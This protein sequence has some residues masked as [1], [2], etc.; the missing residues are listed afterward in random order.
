MLLFC[1]ALHI[2]MSEEDDLYMTDEAISIYCVVSQCAPV[3]IRSNIVHICTY[4][5]H[6]Y[7]ALVLHVLL[8][9]LWIPSRGGFHIFFI[10]RKYF[11]SSD[12][13]SQTTKISSSSFLFYT[14][15]HFILDYLPDLT[16][17]YANIPITLIFILFQ[18][19]D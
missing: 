6:R 8:D 13:E 3:K 14:P 11:Q 2:S 4:S 16:L 15:S 9:Q 19:A 18:F 5:I 12:K 10:F 1:I 17:K 7:S